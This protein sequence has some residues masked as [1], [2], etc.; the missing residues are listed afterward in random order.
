MSKVKRPYPALLKMKKYIYKPPPFLT[1]PI[2]FLQSLNEFLLSCIL[3]TCI[4]WF[5]IPQWKALIQFIKLHVSL[6]DGVILIHL[7]LYVNN[8]TFRLKLMKE[9]KESEWALNAT[10]VTHCILIHI[11]PP[12]QT[13]PAVHSVGQHGARLQLQT[14]VSGSYSED[15]LKIVRP[16][17]PEQLD[18][19]CLSRLC[20]N[21]GPGNVKQ[22]HMRLVSI[23]TI[24]IVVFAD[25][26][27]CTKHMFELMMGLRVLLVVF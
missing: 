2:F 19:V 11:S 17:I 23:Q 13:V 14:R 22:K 16:N 7:P 25:R 18:S 24:S 10:I 12:Q 21:N 6:K 3:T 5:Y 27:F 20:V 26:P 15:V 9:T 1:L 4:T 8:V